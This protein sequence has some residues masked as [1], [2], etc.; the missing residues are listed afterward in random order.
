MKDQVKVAEKLGARIVKRTRWRAPG[1][2]EEQE[3]AEKFK[4]ATR[5]WERNVNWFL[6]RQETRMDMQ[7]YLDKEYMEDALSDELEKD[8]DSFDLVLAAEYQTG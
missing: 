5:E 2:V 6:K 7:W 1:D 3:W 4:E 8:R